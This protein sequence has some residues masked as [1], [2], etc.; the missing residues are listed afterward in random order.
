MI[1]HL[2]GLV[3]R[4]ENNLAAVEQWVA[5]SSWAAFLA[6]DQ[7]A[8][9]CTSIC[10]KITDPWF[11][12]LAPEAQAEAAKK[13]ASM[14][15]KEAV[16]YDIGAYRDAPAGL[17]IWGGATVETADIRALL[18]WLDWAWNEVKNTAAKAA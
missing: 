4:S 17:R 13:I 8:R 6:E 5:G 16:A 10:L 9:S 1:H 3:A 11:T 2:T 15:D 18:P 14:L 12:G 7:N